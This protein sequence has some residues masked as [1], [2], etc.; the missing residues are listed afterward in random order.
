MP[1]R[2]KAF[3]VHLGGSS[4]IALLVLLLVFR[5]WYPAPLH[6]AVGVTNIFLL[7]LLIDVILGPLLTLVVYK[8]GKKTLVF[9]LAVIALL[10]LSA[11][12]Y[13]L[14]AVADGRPAWLVF[15]TD[16]FDLVRVLDVD[17]RK[18]DQARPEFRQPSW[19]GPRWAIAVPPDDAVARTELLFETVQ[20]GSD[21]PQRPELYQPLADNRERVKERLHL[22]PALQEYN[23]A[24]EVNAAIGP[25]PE[26]DA[27][28]PLM[29]GVPMVVLLHKETA[30][31]VAVVDLR[32]WL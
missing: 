2:L 25:W 29:A 1:I 8:A 14:H 24:D 18:L 30:E 22:L 32:P 15:N 20:G 4:I 27:W 3:F 23:S 10:Q 21:L 11:L 7:L 28:L 31:V 9:D 13:G 26:A 19:F 16:R 12:I 5:L 17:T 6:V